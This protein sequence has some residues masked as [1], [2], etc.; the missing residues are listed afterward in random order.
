ML[1]ILDKYDFDGIDID[2]E[3]PV[4]GGAHEGTTA[5]KANYVISFLKNIRSSLIEFQTR[6]G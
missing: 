5:D 3:Y 6:K 2:W 4:K 1:N